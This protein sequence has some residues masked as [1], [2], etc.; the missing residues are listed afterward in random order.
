VS[1]KEWGKLVPN[2]RNNDWKSDWVI[3]AGTGFWYHR[4]VE[5]PFKIN[6]PQSHPYKGNN[7]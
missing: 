4:S 5:A 6:L 2:G 3:P 1:K 7:R